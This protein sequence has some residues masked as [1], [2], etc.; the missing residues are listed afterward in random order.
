[1]Y[2]YYIFDIYIL[3]IIYIYCIFDSRSEFSVTDETMGKNVTMF[4]AYLCIL[5]IKIK[6]S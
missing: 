4:G 1:M 5:I 3:Y 2:I 6:I